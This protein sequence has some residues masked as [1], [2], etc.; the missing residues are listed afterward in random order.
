ME[1]TS[2]GKRLVEKVWS[3]DNISFFCSHCNPCLFI[4]CV[5]CVR[6]SVCVRMRV[7]VCLH[8]KKMLMGFL[9]EGS[10]TKGIKSRCKTAGC[11][12]HHCFVKN[13]HSFYNHRDRWSFEKMSVQQSHLPTWTEF[14]PSFKG[15]NSPYIIFFNGT[16]ITRRVY[17]KYSF[18]P[19]HAAAVNI[20]FSGIQKVQKQ[21]FEKYM[22][23]Q[24]VFSCLIRQFSFYLGW[25]FCFFKLRELLCNEMAVR[26]LWRKFCSPYQAW[27][28]GVFKFAYKKPNM[29][30]L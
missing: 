27:K 3:W 23:V 26:S 14:L 18:P 20:A 30:L 6:W 7:L 12:I 28:H 4:L 16:Q 11:R 13:K 29:F 15:T 5:H 25:I 1:F 17:A 8:F 2:L 22:Q 21:L 24:I 19:K 9:Q 10:I